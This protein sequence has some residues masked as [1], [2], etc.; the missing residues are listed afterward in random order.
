MT[1]ARFAAVSSDDIP[2][3]TAASSSAWR[4]ALSSAW[5]ARTRAFAGEAEASA[6]YGSPVFTV[7]GVPEAP[8]TENVPPAT[9]FFPSF[10]SLATSARVL[11]RAETEV[12]ALPAAA[13]GVG[14]GVEADEGAAATWARRAIT[15]ITV[16]I[17]SWPPPE[18]PD[19]VGEEPDIVEHVRTDECCS[20]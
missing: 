8:A 15:S 17:L 2:F 20:S 6:A 3:R 12:E 4:A 14:A 10:R 11:G 9:P 5:A 16:R 19:L 18:K 13:G 7:A 1:R